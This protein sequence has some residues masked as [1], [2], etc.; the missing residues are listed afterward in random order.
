VK[1]STFV[2][3]WLY[4][5]NPRIYA[6]SG[7]GAMHLNDA[8]C[9]SKLEVMAMHHEQACAYA[10]EADYR[11]S[12]RPGLVHVTT[13]PGGANAVTGIACAFVDSV[14]MIVIA[15]Q[16]TSP[17]MKPAAM[18]QFGIN[19]LD[20][21]SMVKPIT[22][23]AVTVRDPNTISWHLENAL[24]LATSGRPGP[25][26]IEI[27]LD[28]QN[29]EIEPVK[30]LRLER[31]ST[32]SRHSVME[33]A[34]LLAEAKRPVLF[35]GNGIHVSGAE[36]SLCALATLLEIPVVTSW[37]A[38]D[39][40]A[41][42]MIGRPGLFGDRAGNWTVQHADFIL[43]IG[44]RL[45][46]P[47]TGHH[48]DRFAPNAKKVVVDIDPEEALKLKPMRAVA[49][50][51]KHFLDLFYQEWK[52]QI[53]PSWREWLDRCR[54]WKSD[55]PV[56]R[57]EYRNVTQGVNAYYFV[58][59]LGRHLPDNAVVVTDVGYAYIATMQSLQ[60]RRGQRL[61]HSGGVSPMG[62]GL[63]AAIGA[64]R[65]GRKT[66]CL[67]G[68]GGLMFNLQE[69]HTVVEHQ[70]PITIFV[71]ANHGYKTIQTMQ[72][73]H[74]GRESISGPNSGLTCPD[75][76]ELGRAFGIP[77]EA[78]FDHK[79]LEDWMDYRVNRPHPMLVVVHMADHPIAPRV[80]SR[81]ENGK[82]VPTDIGDMWPHL[83]A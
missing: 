58:E 18:R 44:T 26:F 56:M 64:C 2:A 38:I 82:F 51:A 24:S 78:V 31:S 39:L 55:Y 25:V 72:M 49:A 60:L 48:L 6:I 76:V 37:N 50:D 52:K 67:T 12:G 11:V 23:Y 80:Q 9:H 41:P 77:N 22:K 57:S 28:V 20:V 19:E 45:S 30:P 69:L 66:I 63:P 3:D 15:G 17:T 29:A 32:L 46:I 53:A 1:L 4:E 43:A 35:V 36:D 83:A 65:G 75:F 8:I 81:V 79:N 40:C 59:Q 47:Q 62:Y 14:P 5:V 42:C 7:G 10:A 34:R 33:C 13:G 70:L 73:N 21:V 54:T 61:F 74:F 16:V 27:P 68:D 71:F